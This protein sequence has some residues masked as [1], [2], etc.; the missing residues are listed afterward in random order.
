MRTLSWG[1]LLAS[2]LAVAGAGAQSATQTLN[3]QPSDADV[4]SAQSARAGVRHYL[5]TA[6]HHQTREGVRDLTVKPFA[7]PAPGSPTPGVRV[8]GT[9]TFQGGQVVQ[10]AQ[11]HAIYLFPR[12]GACPNVAACW[13]NPEQFLFDLGRSQFMHVTDQYV[14][15]TANNRYTVGVS[16]RV[17]YTI[18]AL[19]LV[20][21]DIQAIVHNM[22]KQDG[23]LA[24]Y[25]HEY[26]VFLPPGQDECFDTTYT[27]CASNVFCAY[28]GSTDFSDV[29]HVI[30]SVEPYG[31]VPGC[32]QLLP[33][34]T[35]VTGQNS[36]LSHELIESITDPD[37]DAWWNFNGNLDLYG[38]EIGDE[39]QWFTVD[40]AGNG[41]FLFDNVTLNGRHYM[42]QS[43]YNNHANGCTDGP[44]GGD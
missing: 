12:N 18:P 6:G 15:T 19:P 3:L 37:G 7:P 31:N 20:D 22:V 38:Y 25:G 27:V 21:S 2:C 11:Q 23:G 40:S 17:H 14:G 33:D 10:N 42:I 28:H 9:L 35:S 1:L 13:G 43:E 8:L 16:G 32:T 5:P 34:G 36:I 30:Y 4:A 44:G 26:H 29:G 24:G 39:C 41:G